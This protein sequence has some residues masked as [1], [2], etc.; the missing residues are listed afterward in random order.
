MDHGNENRNTCRGSMKRL[1]SRKNRASPKNIPLAREPQNLNREIE[2]SWK[3]SDSLDA[4]HGFIDVESKIIVILAT[5]N[6]VIDVAELIQNNRDASIHVISPSS[7]PSWR[8]DGT[9]VKFQPAINFG[10]INWLIRL[11][12]PVD[13][14]MNIRNTSAK[15]HATYWRKLFPHVRPM[16]SYEAPMEYALSEGADN[17]YTLVTRNFPKKTPDDP[18]FEMHNSILNFSANAETFRITK[19]SKHYIKYR[20]ADASRFLG[21][22]T[23]NLIVEE[24][25]R[26]PGTQFKSRA[27]I[28]SHES[29]VAIQ[30]ILK[31]F[32]VPALQLRKYTGKIGVIANSLLISDFDI[33][34]DTFKFPVASKLLNVNLINIDDNFARI[35]E[36]LIPKRRLRGSYYHVDSTNSGHFG[37]L[38]G[39]VLA[40][41]WGWPIAKK[42]DEN[43]KVLFRIRFPNERRPEL[44]RK[45]FQAY[46]IPLADIVW[47]D[48]PVWVDSLIAAAPMWQNQIPH[49]V[50]PAIQN[51]WTKIGSSLIDGAG[52]TYEKM[53]ISRA[54]NF[55][56]RAC[57]NIKDVEEFFENQGF[58]IVYPEDLTLNDQANIF[59]RARV[60]A[61]F[62]GSAMFNLVFATQLQNLIVLNQEAYT[63]RNEHLFSSVLGCNVDYFWSTPEIEHPTGAWSQEAYVSPWSFDFE[64]NKEPLETLLNGL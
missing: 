36:N 57:R 54:S 29:K 40:C 61:G 56:D 24:L 60:I 20:H 30:H 25:D 13:T 38:M 33:L 44:E 23:N 4:S 59:S 32:T 64:R 39:E 31:E 46:G 3:D 34:P 5:E 6:S 21:A 43:L 63:A 41:L 11:I 50:H 17:L 52:P 58:E 49:Y 22:R 1:F 53:F 48:E 10:Q 62:G 45:I 28:S 26:L 51:I 14:L 2:N 35:P 18:E 27:N 9:S 42:H 15:E 47:I 12:G 16:G 37:H 8:L 19:R 55:S 7:N